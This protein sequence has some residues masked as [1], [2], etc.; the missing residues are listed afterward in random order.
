MKRDMRKAGTK[1]PTL[2]DESMDFEVAI[3]RLADTASDAE[4]E[5]KI[6]EAHGATIS[7]SE[8]DE[9]G[10]KRNLFRICFPE[11]ARRAS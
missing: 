6:V 2:W 4:L 3:T 1:V 11:P 5:G 8:V 7:F 9:G 10:S